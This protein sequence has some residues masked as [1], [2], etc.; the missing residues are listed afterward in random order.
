MRKLNSAWPVLLMA[1][2]FGCTPERGTP[3]TTRPQAVLDSPKSVEG[4][5]DTAV[6]AALAEMPE[7]ATH[8]NWYGPAIVFVD[9]RQFKTFGFAYH[10]EPARVSRLLALGVDF[11]V[12]RVSEIWQKYADRPLCLAF[13]L[14]ATE[15]K[16][17]NG[18]GR[19]MCTFARRY[20]T[21]DCDPVLRM[22]A[23]RVVARWGD[24]RDLNALDALAQSEAGLV[25][26]TAGW[27]EAIVT[28]YSEAPNVRSRP[29]DEY[30]D[31][32]HTNAIL[33]GD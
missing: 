32:R 16:L 10:E 13:L 8:S 1:M 30:P 18:Q 12:F 7:V 28:K 20:L 17:R 24:A 2:A 23:I 15:A 14:T 3:P 33:D 22:A 19:T 29:L 21:S 9:A 4:P 5:F 6:A 11:E 26:S 27:A 25:K 31:S